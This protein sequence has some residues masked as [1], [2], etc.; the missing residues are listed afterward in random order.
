MAGKVAVPTDS[1]GLREVLLNRS[2]LD[3]VY[4]D[5]D[6]FAEFMTNYAKAANKTGDIESM[7]N[8]RIQEALTSFA[9]D[10]F[11][12]L[13]RPD[14][15]NANFQDVRQS[16]QTGAAYMK[17]A[18]GAKLDGDF[19]DFADFFNTINHRADRTEPDRRA[20]IDKIKN[21]LSSDIP[22]EGGF[23]IPEEFRAE[24]LR[25]AL[26]SAIVRPRARVIPM[27]TARVSMPMVDSTTN[28]GSLFGGVVA[29][30][31]EEAASL[32]ESSPTF[33][34]VTLD[35]SKLTAYSDL[36]NELGDDAMPALQAFLSMAFPEVLAFSED[37][38]FL[39]GDGAGQPLGALNS[40]NGAI[41][42][43][44]PTASGNSI[45]WAD[46]VN[47]Y[48]RMLPSSLSRA[49]WVCS[50]DVFPQLAMMQAPGGTGSGPIWLTDGTSA[51]KLTI[52]GRPV[53]ISEKVPGLGTQGDLSF[54]DFGYYL[55]GDRMA[56][57]AAT[58]PHYKFGQ[59]ITSYRVIERV[60][61]QPWLKSPITPRNGS[62]STLSPFVQLSA[63]GR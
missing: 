53:E 52:L 62:S 33:S 23:L 55:I 43:Q 17:S 35:A 36:P 12:N 29:Y 60:D 16:R 26:E 40:A 46:V 48:S 44:T 24:L 6:S 56:M 18:V 15:R 34:K 49:V 25:V 10:N 42:A 39:M 63:T 58:S 57:T 51:P 9:K 21:A 54:V 2:K 32:V 47:M 61:G 19:A 28:N 27:T 22:A 45:E 8:D 20:K 50:P 7:V 41:I 4:A 37:E 31:T 1:E 30:W 13:K 11:V 59:D 14:M 38:A 3:E 5:P